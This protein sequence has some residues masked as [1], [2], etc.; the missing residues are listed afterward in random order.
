MDRYIALDLET[1]G[2][3]PKQDRIIEIG[4]VKVEN[5]QITEVYSTFVNPHMAIP[6]RIR[7]LTGITTEMAA[8]GADGEEA[9]TSLVEFCQ[10]Y[11]LLGHNIMFDFAFVKHKAVNMGMTFEREGM[12]TL[13]IARKVLQKLESRK[14]DALC[15]YYGIECEHFHRASDDAMAA[16]LLYQKL[17]AEYQEVNPEIFRPQP[18]VRTVKKQGPITPS[19]KVYL[20]DLVKYH[21][22]ELDVQISSLTKNEASRLIDRIISEHGRIMR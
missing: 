1:T 17:R 19:Q 8:S 12:D 18:L 15:R 4:A 10:D 16:H 3:S 11:P 13:M 22:I 9:I 2:L 21:R 6:P 20:N 14:L 7:Q 5:N